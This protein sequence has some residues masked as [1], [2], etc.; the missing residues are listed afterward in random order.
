[1]TGAP[2]DGHAG[3]ARIDDERAAAQFGRALAAG[4]P[5]QRAQPGQHFL[6]LERLRHVVVGAA[7]DALHLLV[8]A[9]ARGEHEHRQ[10]Q[11]GVAPAAQHGQSVDVRQSQIEHDRV[12]LFGA[13]QKIR[14]RAVRRR[15]DRVARL[16]QRADQLPGQARFI[17]DDEHTH[18]T[19]IA[20]AA[21]LNGSEP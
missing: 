9:A 1:M 12:V 10:P 21:G 15:V 18:R 7:V 20:Q 11:A 2:V 6:H 13:R 14:L 16:A 4:A 17:F 19:V 3:A 8:P 5:D